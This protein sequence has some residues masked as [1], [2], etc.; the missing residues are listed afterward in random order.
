MKTLEI[1]NKEVT[2][3]RLLQKARE[4]PGAWTGLKIAVLILMKAGW[5]PKDL[6]SVFGLNRQTMT[7]WIHQVNEGGL[8]RI[9]KNP[10]PGRPK[11]LT[12]AV[13]KQLEKDLSQAPETFGLPNGHWNAPVLAT[14]LA[15]RFGIKIKTRQAR[16][17]LYRMG[18]TVKKAGYVY[19]QSRAEDAQKFSKTLKKTPRAEAQRDHCL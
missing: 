1:E 5:R 6:E 2:V 16:N 4:I 8:E 17:W 19:L 13:G 7:R 12:E 14:H 3:S 10:P 15:Q 11:G 18:Y 9:E